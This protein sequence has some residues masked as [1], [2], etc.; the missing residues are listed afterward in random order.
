M[1]WKET[2]T[3]DEREAFV[4]AWLSREFSMSELCTR[5]AVSRPTGYKWVERFC[6]EG[7]LGLADHSRAPALHPNATAADQ[8]A[9]ILALKRRHAS[10]GP[11]TVRDWLRRE[12]PAQHWPAASTIGTLLKAHGL[13]EPRRTRRPQA[14]PRASSHWAINGSA[15]H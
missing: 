1:P 10:W 9:A 13:V 11:I 15:I 5:F 4:Q 14:P 12:H 3:V 2:C 8:V 6:A 7:M